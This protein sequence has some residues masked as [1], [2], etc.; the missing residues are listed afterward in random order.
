MSTTTLSDQ[1]PILITGTSHTAVERLADL[2]HDESDWH[3]TTMVVTPIQPVAD[4]L[5]EA[6]ATDG[7]VRAII[8]AGGDGDLQILDALGTMDHHLR[9][10]VIVCGRLQ[11]AEATRAAIRAGAADLLSENPTSSE[12]V[13]AL[14][15]AV[16]NVRQPE[17]HSDA[18]RLVTIIGAAGGVGAS[19]IACTLAHLS[20]A[21]WHRRTLLI[22]SDPLYATLGAALGLKPQRGLA[23]A[24]QQLGTLDATALQGY[25][26]RHSSGLGLLS[27]VEDSVLGAPIDSD[28]FATLLH[29]LRES[30]EQVF[31]EGRRWLE[32]ETVVAVNESQHILLVL[33]QSVLHVHNAARLFHILTQHLNV[34]PSRITVVLNRY[35]RRATVQ[36]DTVSKIIGCGEP[37]LIPSM[38]GLAL[39][40]MDAAIPLFELDQKSALARALIDLGSH[41]V[42]NVKTEPP[43]LLRRAFSAMT[44]M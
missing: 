7:A 38:H 3:V 28:A 37:I 26:T 39:D 40:S 32:P 1:L 11:S 41:V 10:P 21:V 16:L 19:F 15:R 23:E 4:A 44:R 25:I 29:L 36:P 22:D 9:A 17:P 34:P 30:H 8:V 6:T 24:L 2:L 20:A 5:A 33:E 13:T 35:S 12:L 27:C 42:S 18:G 43:G 31:M 14:Q